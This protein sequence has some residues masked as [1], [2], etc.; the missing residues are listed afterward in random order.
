MRGN[1]VGAHFWRA[2]V[3]RSMADAGVVVGADGAGGDRDSGSEKK[4][5]NNAF[6]G[7]APDVAE[8]KQAHES[9]WGV[10]ADAERAGMPLG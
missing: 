8:W 10:V 1:D 7:G 2:V 6:H 5:D 3:G 4:H 9:R